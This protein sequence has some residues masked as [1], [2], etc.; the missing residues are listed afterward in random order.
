MRVFHVFTIREASFRA[1]A[2]FTRRYEF[3]Y[4]VLLSPK[5]VRRILDVEYCLLLFH[6]DPIVFEHPGIHPCVL[7]FEIQCW[8]WRL[9]FQKKMI[10]AMRAIFVAAYMISAPN[11]EPRISH[12][13][14]LKCL[15]VLPEAFPAFLASKRLQLAQFRYS[16]AKTVSYTR[17]FFLPCQVSEVVHDLLA[18]RG[19][20]HNQTTYDLLICIGGGLL[21]YATVVTYS[22]AL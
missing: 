16:Q 11:F 22:M 8:L 2:R 9:G 18:L 12:S 6:A 13:P 15:G 10:I 4:P 5:S 19:T 17:F 7:T 20:P 14:L 21:R 3:L 1:A